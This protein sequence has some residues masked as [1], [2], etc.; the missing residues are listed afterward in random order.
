MR[1][2]NDMRLDNSTCV[3]DILSLDYRDSLADESTYMPVI[4]PELRSGI[5][6]YS[7][8]WYKVKT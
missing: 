3:D 2:G 7:S 6:P 4:Y 8:L 5:M 1:F